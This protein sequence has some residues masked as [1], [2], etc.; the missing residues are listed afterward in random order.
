MKTLTLKYSFVATWVAWIYHTMVYFGLNDVQGVISELK[1]TIC[2][3]GMVVRG[4][5]CT[6][7]AENVWVVTVQTC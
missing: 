4:V 3:A 5:I 1:R 6:F 7:F 2:S